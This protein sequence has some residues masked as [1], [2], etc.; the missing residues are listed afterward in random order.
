MRTPARLSVA[1]VAASLIGLV[2]GC[3]PEPEVTPSASATATA[4]PTSTSEPTP[5][6]TVEPTPT[7]TAGAPIVIPECIDLV[8]L[9]LMQE[10]IAPE[11][12]ALELPIAVEDAM[13]DAST[14]TAIAVATQTK[15]C[16]WGIPDSDGVMGV[17]V[18]QLDE[19]DREAAIEG[20]R[21]EATTTEST[22]GNAISFT[23]EE[24]SGVGLVSTTYAF[25]GTAWVTVTGTG[26]AAS[27]EAVAA[28]ALASIRGV[29]PGLD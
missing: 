24:E 5:T 23:R 1:L 16:A 25:L 4:A 7:A 17:I 28:A 14:A 6:E 22:I 13:T 11:A 20:L 2:A 9:D 15:S 19:A 21:E 12:V 29:N 3:A 18:A 8:A 10:Q 27:A 26:F